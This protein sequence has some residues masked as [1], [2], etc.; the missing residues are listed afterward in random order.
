MEQLTRPFK[1]V[2]YSQKKRI[3]NERENIHFQTLGF[4]TL[5]SFCIPDIGR[6]TA[7]STHIYATGFS[8]IRF[9]CTKTQSDSAA[10][11]DSSKCASPYCSCIPVRER[12]LVIFGEGG[13]LSVQ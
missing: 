7:M 8:L 4:E 10:C 12:I 5:P 2:V 6:G 11:A 3:S 1:I 9:S 13:V